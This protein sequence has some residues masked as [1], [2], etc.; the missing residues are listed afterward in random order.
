M[1]MEFVNI[2]KQAIKNK[3]LGNFSAGDSSD[4]IRNKMIEL[5]GGSTKVNIK[6]FHRGSALFSLI[7]ELLPEV[8]N[9]GLANNPQLAAL[10]DYK[11]IADGDQNEF[12]LPGNTYFVVRDTAAGIYGVRRQKIGDRQTVTVPTKVKIIRVYDD[13]GRFL[14][15][16]VD[17]N[18]LIDMI[19]RNF[20]RQIVEDAYVCL[21][22]VTAGTVGMSSDYVIGGTFS[23]DALK[24]LVAHVEAANPG[25]KAMIIGTKIALG[26]ITTASA[27]SDQAKNDLYGLGYYGKFFGTDMLATANAHKAD[28]KTFVMSDSKIFVIAADDKPIKVVNEGEGFM[29][30]RQATDNA[31]ATQEYTY[32]QAVGV[33]FAPAAKMGICNLG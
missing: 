16:R 24:T 4:A 17:F 2:C 18:E 7:E 21:S 25:K 14:A 28:G 32:G 6:T 30:E 3:T 22:N 33:A 26:K 13:L 20:I 31:D 11:N 12:V 29:F 10:I 19:A 27:A 9:D 23:E 15:G 1:D 5:N 8:I